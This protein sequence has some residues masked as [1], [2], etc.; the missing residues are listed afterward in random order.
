MKKL[1]ASLAVI[2]ALTAVAA[3]IAAA[4]APD[5]HPRGVACPALN[6][7]DASNFG[8]AQALRIHDCQ[9]S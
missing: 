3:P 4:E 1:L 9:I 6:G 7:V 8:I 2:G 5:P